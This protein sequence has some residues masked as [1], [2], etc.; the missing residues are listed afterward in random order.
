[1]NNFNINIKEIDMKINFPDMYKDYH[2]VKELNFQFN[3]F[4]AGIRDEDVLA[5]AP[6]IKNYADWKRE[7]LS[8]AALAEKERR[9]MNAA[10]YY[11]LAEFF[12]DP[13]DPDKN[14]AYEKFT[15]LMN[16]LYK[17]EN[18]KRISI[19]YKNAYLPAVS[20]KGVGKKGTIVMHGGFDSFIEEFYPVLLYL[21][22]SG[23]DI[24]AF[25]G[26]GQGA[27]LRKHG[28]HMTHEWEKPVA[29]VLDYFKVSDVTL[30]GM[31]LGGY[32]ALR[33]AA[34][35]KRISRVVAFDA[36]YEFI[37]CFLNRK[38]PAGKYALK[39]LLALR[40]VFI[41]NVAIYVIMKTDL[42]AEWGIRQGMH[43][44]GVNSPYRLF[45]KLADFTTK[46][47]S[48][49][50]TQDVLV[51]AGSEDHY[52]PLRQFHAQMKALVSARSVTGR[53]FT[54]AEN[55]QNHCQVGNVGIA[56]DVIV[57]W[58]E[59]CRRNKQ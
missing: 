38:G 4:A 43:V 30:V 31:S 41:V 56:L 51:L 55:A 52:V 19:P 10:S 40:A 23:Y 47:I 33:A 9:F 42:L 2:P 32:L 36:M 11:R 3:R 26:P 8:I 34:F 13:R 6:R 17:N 44:M 14:R 16:D 29:A 57:N 25:E 27:M 24:I 39:L 21:K 45:K 22:S 20:L 35:D 53:I 50:I 37:E 7:N 1:V 54:R 49:S 5:I 18:I 46:N 58:I 59:L 28:V 12:M 48:K 15:G